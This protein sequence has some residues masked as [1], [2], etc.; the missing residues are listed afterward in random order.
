MSGMSVYVVGRIVVMLV[1][2]AVVVVVVVLRWLLCWWFGGHHSHCSFGLGWGVCV[3]LWLTRVE[4]G[5]N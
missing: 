3:G 1:V 4:A 5:L 2:V